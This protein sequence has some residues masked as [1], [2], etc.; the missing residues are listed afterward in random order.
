MSGTEARLSFSSGDRI[1]LRFSAPSWRESRR[2]LP[3]AQ[4]REV[5]DGFDPARVRRLLLADS[6]LEHPDYERLAE[7][8]RAKGFPRVELETSAEALAPD[9]AIERVRAAGVVRVIVRSA[10]K[11]CSSSEASTSRANPA[12]ALTTPMLIGRRSAAVP[13]PV[14]PWPLTS[15]SD[16]AWR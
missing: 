4:I 3:A 12:S 11:A 16:T 15:T 5:L 7:A 9:D 14:A 2:F 1:D 10:V 8:V 6:A 13:G